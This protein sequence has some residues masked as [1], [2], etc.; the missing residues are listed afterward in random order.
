VFY[1]DSSAQYGAGSRSMSF[2]WINLAHRFQFALQG[3]SQ[4]QFF[5]AATNGVYLD[6]LLAPVFNDRSNLQATS[7]VRG[8]AANGL[9]PL[10]R[11][12][13][14]EV[15]AGMFD[16]KEEFNDNAQQYLDVFGQPQP[17]V[18]RDGIS[19]PLGVAFV[20]ET[21]VFREFGPLSGST[22]RLAYD[23]EPPIG[24]ALSSRTID[25]DARYYQRIAT[26]GVL[27][28]RAKWF[29]STG[30]NPRYSY[31]GGNSEMRGYNYLE[32]SGE[33]TVFANAELRFPLINAALTPIGVIGGIRGVFFADIGGGWFKSQQGYQFFAN[34]PERFTPIV[35]YERNVLGDIVLD[36]QTGYPIPVYGPTQIIRGFRLR[37]GRAS[38]GLGLETF[39]IGLPLHFD[40][41]WRTLFNKEWEDALFAYSGG[42]REFRHA[43][44]SFWIGYDF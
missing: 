13:R 27:A 11:F 8:G 18:F 16:V 41:A 15:S 40:W 33:T 43:R 3:V 2:Q 12:R 38:Y 20:Q 29:R 10:D 31:F 39:L 14:M 32:F 1:A 17:Q 4:T 9:Y 23:T 34:D 30:D 35:D 24:K 25:T 36:P 42:S 21:T 28:L 7:R 22:M 19:V 37:D 44:F 5:Y 26:S 6:P